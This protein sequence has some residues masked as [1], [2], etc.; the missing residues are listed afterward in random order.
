MVG[1]H[2]AVV[3]AAVLTALLWPSTEL[4]FVSLAICYAASYR[5]SRAAHPDRHDRS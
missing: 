3:A 5:Y 1:A 2:L 4:S